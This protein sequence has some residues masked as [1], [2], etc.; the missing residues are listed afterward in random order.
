MNPIDTKIA[1]SLRERI[2]T[3][4]DPD[5]AITN[6]KN[7]LSSVLIRQEI[8]H[9]QPSSMALATGI[10]QLEPGES[11]PCPKT[12]SHN[13][14]VTETARDAPPEGLHLSLDQLFHNL[15]RLRKASA[16][17]ADKTLPIRLLC[18]I[19]KTAPSGEIGV[20]GVSEIDNRIRV[21][22][23]MIEEEVSNLETLAGEI[24]I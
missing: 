15:D 4:V 10:R 14:Y 2:S 24:R 7:F 19:G 1:D 8:E 20:G 23:A 13:D 11:Y 3:V 12:T 22:I 21:A 9:P 17:V 18:P 16:K 6:Y 5:E